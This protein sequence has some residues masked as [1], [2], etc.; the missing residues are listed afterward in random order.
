MVAVRHLGFVI[1]QFWTTREVPITDCIFPGN[2]VMIR[3][4]VSETLQ[5][6]VMLI[7][8]IIEEGVVVK[9]DQEVRS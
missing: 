2:G 7:W 4:D 6:C 1:L 9:I 8:S 3:S 5:N